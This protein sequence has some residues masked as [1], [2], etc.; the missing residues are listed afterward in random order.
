M[1]RQRTEFET[2][3]WP[4]R[5]RFGFSEVCQGSLA[6]RKDPGNL[7][8][9]TGSGSKEKISHISDAPQFQPASFCLQAFLVLLLSKPLTTWTILNWPETKKRAH[10]ALWCSDNLCPHGH[11]CE[12]SGERGR[13]KGLDSG[14]IRSKHVLRG[15]KRP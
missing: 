12:D 11:W 13:E 9:E 6:N 2:K 15:Q 14:Y 1:S 3:S 7:V 10:I 4:L 8:L 5:S